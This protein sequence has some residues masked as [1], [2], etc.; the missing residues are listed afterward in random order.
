M[1]LPSKPGDKLVH[2]K[3]PTMTGRK[4][5]TK[6]AIQNKKEMELKSA[7]VKASVGAS[8]SGTV[9]PKQPRI[10]QS[11]GGFSLLANLV[12]SMLPHELY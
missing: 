12:C 2:P 6:N 7:E 8:S 4:K 11:I 5:P 9:T 10:S 3:R 1:V